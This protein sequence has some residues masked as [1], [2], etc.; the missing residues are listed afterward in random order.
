MLVSH[1][2][3]NF[4]ICLK[5]ISIVYRSSEVIFNNLIV[6]LSSELLITIFVGEFF[7]FYTYVNT[8]KIVCNR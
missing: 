7:F 1:L 5:I 2:L 3:V 6:E 8:R 4:E